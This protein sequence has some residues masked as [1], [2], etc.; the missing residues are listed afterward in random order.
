MLIL[1]RKLKQ[2]IVIQNN[3]VVTVL[4]VDGERVKL[5]ITAPPDVVVLRQELCQAVEEENR[6]AAGFPRDHVS[7]VMQALTRLKAP[8]A[9]NRP[10]GSQQPGTEPG[11]ER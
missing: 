7:S 9:G 11:E 8:Q 10:V 2:G 6:A 5:G 1:T 3:I 4:A